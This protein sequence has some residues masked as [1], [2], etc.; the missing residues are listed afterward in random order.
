MCRLF[1]FLLLFLF[2][3]NLSA[4]TKVLVF[5]G[6]S[7][8]DSV[9]KKLINE[10][11]KIASELSTDV[12]FIDLKEYPISLYDG[13]FETKY[14]MPENAKY[15]RKLMIESQVILIASPEHNSSLSAVLKNTIDWASR[16]EKNG[17]SFDAFKGKK[18]VIMSASPGAGGGAKGLNH[19]RII[20]EDLGGIVL[21]EQIVISHAYSAFD[22]QGK[23]KSEKLYA[24]LQRLIK[25]AITPN[26][27]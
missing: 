14:G 7:R 11:A 9:N 6:S 4:Q 24:D 3:I 5:S 16:S 10:A 25:N 23:L 13:D 15:I 19:L 2:S 20:L 27:Y 1:T 8:A 17:S 22:E 12:T 21:P 26:S 18:F